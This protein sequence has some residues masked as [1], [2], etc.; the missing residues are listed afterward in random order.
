MTVF[1]ARELR[2]EY[3][4]TLGITVENTLENAL[5]SPAELF[6]SSA[7]EGEPARRSTAIGS[8]SV[9]THSGRR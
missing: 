7:R 3:S 6:S 1:L 5:Q 8:T 2:R 9:G 4:G